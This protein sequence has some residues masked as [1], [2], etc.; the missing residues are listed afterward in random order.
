MPF[1]RV[2]EARFSGVFVKGARRGRIG[3]LRRFEL[4][5]ESGVTRSPDLSK[6]HTYL[7]F[8][9]VRRGEGGLI[10]RAKKLGSGVCGRYL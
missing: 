3:F 1:F 5:S 7:G 2:N 6:L 9:Y 8:I 10:T 4:P